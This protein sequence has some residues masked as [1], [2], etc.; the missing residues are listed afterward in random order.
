MRGKRS[1]FT[2][3]ELLVVV[4]IVAILAALAV[5]ALNAANRQAQTAQCATKLKSLGAAISLY[6][7]ENQ[8]EL[9]RSWHSA[10]AH[11]QSGWAA[12]IA[13]YLGVTDEQIQNN[14]AGV[15]DQHFRS[16][17]DSSEESP[18]IYSYG[19]NV[20]FELDPNG[21][22]Y[23]GQPATWRRLQQIPR[24]TRTILLAQTRPIMFGDHL[25]CH[26]WNSIDAAK[27]AL[28]HEAHNGRANYL[29]VDGHVELLAVEQTFA[30]SQELN[31]WNPELAR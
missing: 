4:S 18:F 22:D 21:D 10:G 16:P 1:A 14:W 25:M 6:T 5:P 30:P 20:H 8:G 2:L 31:L 12:S 26:L 15:F 28:N 29:F 17:T 24:P 23:V 7:I 11:R 9:P 13:P 3:I 27:N 19:M